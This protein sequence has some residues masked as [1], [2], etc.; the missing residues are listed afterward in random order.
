MRIYALYWKNKGILRLMLALFLILSSAGCVV[1]ALFL[2]NMEGMI[3]DEL[4]GF[5]LFT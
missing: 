3:Y 1:V 2:S 4:L 5:C